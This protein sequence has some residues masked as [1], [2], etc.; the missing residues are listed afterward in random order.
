MHPSDVGSGTETKADRLLRAVQDELGMVPNMM[1]A[2]A[3]SPEVLEAYLNLDAALS[4]GV[5]PP[6]LREQIALAVAEFNGCEYCLAV[7][8]AVGRMNGLSDEAIRDGRRGESP[9][10]RR[11]AALRF[12]RT[13]VERRGRVDDKDVARLRRA[14]YDDA[15]IA[16][17]V[18]NVGAN[19]FANYFNLI[20]GPELDFPRP[21]ELSRGR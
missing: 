11:D 4:R 21:D 3:A 9:D 5:L 14:G 13:V 18:A 19:V 8:T 1:R 7:H 6:C 17:I 10:S 15:A 16:E 2:M 12:V 20:A